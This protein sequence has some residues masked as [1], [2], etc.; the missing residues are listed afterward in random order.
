MRGGDRLGLMTLESFGEAVIRWRIWVILVS[1]LLTAAGGA[2]M[3]KLSY[4][5]NSRLFFAPDDP[6]RI[7]LDQVEDDFTKANSISFIVVPDDG[8]LFTPR[9]LQLVEELTE[10]AWHTPH[11]FR[12]D[13]LSNH[14]LRSAE[15]DDILVK[16]LYQNAAELSA[17]EIAQ[18]KEEALGN[19]SLVGL[20]I[21]ESGDVG[22][23]N[24]LVQTPEIDSRAAIVSASQYAYD[25]AEELEER[26]PGSE[27]KL[28][29]GVISDFTFADAA[30]RDS[31]SLVPAMILIII[32]TLSIALRSWISVLSTMVIVALST[33][34]ALGCG[35][36]FGYNV[37]AATSG[38][39][40]IV[41]TLCVADCVHLLTTLSLRRSAGDSRRQ[42]I[43]NALKLNFQPIAI[44][45]LT[46]AI[47]FLT[48]NFGKAPPLG[49][50]G[51][52]V[53]IGVTCGFLFSVTTLPAILSFFSSPGAPLLIA[54]KRSMIRLASISIDRK[55]LVLVLFVLA[56]PPIIAGMNRI[57]I[58]DNFVEYFD[59][60]FPFRA[61]TDFME[62]RLTGIHVLL[63]AVP[64]GE[65]GGISQPDYLR[66]LDDFTRWFEAQP[67][68][69][70]VISLSQSIKDINQVMNGDDPAA[71]RIPDTA[72]EV[73]ENLFLLEMSM[74]FGLDLSTYVNV[75]RSATLLSVRLA[76]VGSA[77]VQRISQQ[78]EAW[79]EENAPGYAVRATGLSVLY[80][81]MTEENVRAMLLGTF[82][83]FALVSLILLLVLRD[84]RLGLVS[85]IPNLLPATLIFGL[86]GYVG[87]EVNLAISVIGAMTFGIIVDD[88]VHFL[89]KYQWAR[90]TLGLSPRSAV[91]KTFIVVGPA[92][93]MTSIALVSGFLILSQ[94]GFAVSS[95][96]GILSAMTL[97]SALV[98]D[99]LLLPAVLLIISKGRGS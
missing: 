50:L 65:A 8:S 33:L 10:R 5:P 90:R 59:D 17:T 27:I 64:A 73:A 45:S 6:M 54:G 78:G 14:S 48:L 93:I 47:G 81:Y 70:S 75:D 11:S 61:D 72:Q 67:G 16:D 23:V 99:L 57:V 39:P 79:L 98:T 42:A 36:Y 13:S 2:G 29:G 32:V 28:S 40:V 88:T 52:M 43:I 56:V 63:Y 92:L 30:R 87:G 9:M 83:A 62:E 41:M 60:R 58:D 35:G 26:Y 19:E 53:A 51:N 94:S 4:D 89:S 46:T 85:L 37:N 69:T 95:L 31:A 77:D 86:W 22:A 18:I 80:S 74:P 68:V 21:S 25:L 34:I 1:L 3:L 71:Y 44:T 20:L 91:R 24:V 38:T 7:A 76:Q 96:T 55:W 84:V 15:G 12:V 82:L 97:T 66:S 49:E